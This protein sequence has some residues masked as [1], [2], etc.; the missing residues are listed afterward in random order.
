MHR[1]LACL[2]IALLPGFVVA[3]D[4]NVLR[5]Y[6]WNDYIA[7][8]VLT[9]FEN[10]TGI[11]IVYDTFSTDEELRKAFDD[12]APYDIMVPSHDSLPRLIKE[13]KL[14]SLD[15][16]KLPNAVNLDSQVL[17]KLSAFDPQNIHA[18]PYLWGA[19]GLAINTPKAE[20]AF[21][22]PLPE[23]WSVVFNPEQSAKLASCGISILDAS[24]EVFDGLMNYK[25]RSISHTPPRWIKSAAKTLFAIRPN[26][27]QIDSEEYIEAL[28]AGDLCVAVAWTGDALVAADEGQPVVFV[29]P[30][31]G[32]PMFIDT[33]V[34][35]TN[36]ARPDLAYRF[37]NYLLKPE[38]AA[39]ITT[40]TLY[41]NANAAADQFLSAELRNMP[42]IKLDKQMRRRLTMMPTLQ[43]DTQEAIDAV[44]AEFIEAPT[45]EAL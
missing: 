1:L 42:G 6:N 8:E 40:E 37:I 44:W 36:A 2:L 32:A 4:E 28:N 16:A 34:I 30:E 24:A 25:G 23:S 10:E 9:N 20:S 11:K 21:G 29:V 41:P 5:I 13:G 35:P 45:P 3:A 31:E 39:Q 17:S 26:I 38:V 15:K 18:M 43:D 33:L 12:N 14:T 19:V 22:G 7:P 27:R